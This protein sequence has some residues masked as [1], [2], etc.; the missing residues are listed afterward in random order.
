MRLPD[1]AHVHRQ[2]KSDM[3]RMCLWVCGVAVIALLK[4]KA[5]NERHNAEPSRASSSPSPRASSASD[6]GD[7]V[8]PGGLQITSPRS[9]V[10]TR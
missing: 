3:R 10:P 1:P 5:A 9:T 6:G 2:H 8:A 4:T 7:E